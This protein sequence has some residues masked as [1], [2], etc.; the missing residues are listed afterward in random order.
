VADQAEMTAFGESQADL[1]VL[2]HNLRKR[3]PAINLK[4]RAGPKRI[5]AAA[6]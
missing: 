2:W 5:S 1:G 3:S 6:R 4:R